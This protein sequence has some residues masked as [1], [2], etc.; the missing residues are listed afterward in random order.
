LIVF[1]VQLA[2]MRVSVVAMTHSQST[3]SLGTQFNA[4]LF[5]SI[6]EGVSEAPLSVVSALAR[7]DLDPWEEA[8][9]LTRLPSKTAAQ[10]LA[11]LLAKL[12]GGD[13]THSDSQT[14]AQRLIALLPGPAGPTSGYSSPGDVSGATVPVYLTMI[15]TFFILMSVVAMATSGFTGHPSPAPAAAN[16]A[17]APASGAALSI[18]SLPP[19]TQP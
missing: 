19:K 4:F 16:A 9:E 6:D 11:A 18:P 10:R 14:I 1:G 15:M 3:S 12:P 8:V 7:L 13:P 17:A 2:R 5:A